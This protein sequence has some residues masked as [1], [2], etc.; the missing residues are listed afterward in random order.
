MEMSPLEGGAGTAL[1]ITPMAWG[2]LASPSPHC[3]VSTF[4]SCSKALG[5]V[6]VLTSI[7]MPKVAR[8]SQ[9]RNMKYFQNDEVVITNVSRVSK[10]VLGTTQGSAVSWRF[11][12]CKITACMWFALGM[13]CETFRNFLSVY[14]L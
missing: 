5:S 7:V 12:M 1:S 6:Q 4:A 13:P 14:L 11:S 8:H 2:V 9:Y 10:I 3:T